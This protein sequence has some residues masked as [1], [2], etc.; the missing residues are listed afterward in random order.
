MGTH[1]KRKTAIRI[2]Y[3][4]FRS[5]YIINLQYYKFV[6]YIVYGLISLED[7]IMLEI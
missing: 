5:L 6:S 3:N 2:S 4:K 7:K 1:I